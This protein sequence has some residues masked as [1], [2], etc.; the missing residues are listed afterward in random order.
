[1]FALLMA[2]DFVFLEPPTLS[3]YEWRFVKVFTISETFSHQINKI[4]TSLFLLQIFITYL[5]YL[6]RHSSISEAS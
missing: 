4:S 1:M 5:Y 2:S 3:Q 6:L